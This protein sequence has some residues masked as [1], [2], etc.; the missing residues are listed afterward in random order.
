MT[1]PARQ[2]PVT[3]TEYMNRWLV[4]RLC[5]I[6][7]GMGWWGWTNQML[8]QYD[9]LDPA[10]RGEFVGLVD[11]LNVRLRKARCSPWLLSDEPAVR[12]LGLLALFHF[13]AR[14]NPPQRLIDLPFPEAI[15]K[16]LGAADMW[17]AG[18]ARAFEGVDS[19]PA[20]VVGEFVAF[21][22]GH[23]VDLPVPLVPPAGSAPD[24][25]PRRLR[26]LSSMQR[27][28]VPR[29]GVEADPYALPME[30]ARRVVETALRINGGERS[31]V[32]EPTRFK[33]DLAFGL[34]AYGFP[35][36]AMDGNEAQLLDLS[37]IHAPAPDSPV[38][39][40]VRDELTGL[41]EKA[42]EAQRGRRRRLD[43][44]GG[45]DVGGVC[46]VLSQMADEAVVGR[47]R[48]WREE[49]ALEGMFS[50]G[51][52]HEAGWEMTEDGR[53]RSLHADLLTPLRRRAADEDSRGGAVRVLTP[54]DSACPSCGRGMLALLDVY[55]A[56]PGSEGLEFLGFGRTRLV[57]RFCVECGRHRET[58]GVH[59]VIAD[60][61][62][63]RRAAAPP[64][65]SLAS[66]S[67]PTS[68]IPQ[69]AFVVAGRAEPYW[70]LRRGRRTRLGGP[71]TWEQYPE[72]SSCPT[73]AQTMVFVGQ[74]DC[75]EMDWGDE[76]I[77]A[78]VCRECRVSTTLAQQT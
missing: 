62:A 19:L 75:S 9:A 39:A 49:P 33:R 61:E 69:D 17:V 68:P 20:D 46:Q 28:T 4:Y 23:G 63:P 2:S 59:P 16:V 52:L 15:G 37:I 71:P 22:R 57:I 65:A 78:F 14:E 38:F 32:P 64:A 60:P 34:L 48:A 76:V 70:K 13:P 44:P 53:R 73:C 55:L 10:R 43:R 40:R 21:C 45:V 31:D 41:L 35:R 11:A 25:G 67:D 58:A 42:V 26:A 54:L 77:Y 7:T 6:T 66:S 47:T 29:R 8:A 30:E 1:D 5:F 72:Y 27:A 74:V 51:V 36:E 24:A 50:Q 3:A 12:E 56:Q 18:V